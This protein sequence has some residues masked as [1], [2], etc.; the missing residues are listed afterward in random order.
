MALALRP[1]LSESSMKSKNGSQVLAV[2][3]RVGS[4][5][6]VES[7]DTS[8]AGFAS[9]GAESGDTSLAG[10]ASAGAESGDTSLAGF[11]S[12]GAESGDTSLAGFGGGRRPHAPG[13]RTLM[14]AA[15]R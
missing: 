5:T 14:P 15:F 6:G 2:G 11:E 3:L 7:G 1:L 12:A 9:A 8:L 4:P 13:S 10:F